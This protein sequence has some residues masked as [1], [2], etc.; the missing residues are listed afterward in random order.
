MADGIDARLDQI[1]DDRQGADHVAVERAI[2]HGHLG[3]VA[4][5][6]HQG[7][8]LVGERHEDGAAN[9]RLDVLFGDVRRQS[10]EERRQCVVELGKERVDG[11]GFKADAEIRGQLAAVVDGA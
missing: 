6:E 9:A 8:E 1:A 4:G 7:A 10:G 3:F 11:D 2:A 5:G